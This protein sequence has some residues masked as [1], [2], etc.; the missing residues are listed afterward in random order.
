MM[1]TGTFENVGEAGSVLVGR[2]RGRAGA[3]S[4]NFGVGRPS[5]CGRPVAADPQLAPGSMGKHSWPG[6]RQSV[7]DAGTTWR[8]LKRRC[9]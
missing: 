5:T 3:K 9:P 2:E 4:T 8:G 6:S 7:K 1:V